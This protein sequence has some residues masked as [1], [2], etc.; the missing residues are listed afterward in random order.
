MYVGILPTN[1]DFRTAFFTRL[2][3]S[4]WGFALVAVTT[5]Q[6]I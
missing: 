6:C 4:V 2:N 3:Y 5:I 1:F